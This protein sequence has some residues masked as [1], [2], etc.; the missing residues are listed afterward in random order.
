MEE[1]Q[2]QVVTL[3]GVQGC[4]PTV[5][6]GTD[7]IVLRDDFGGTVRLTKPQWTDLVIR[8]QAGELA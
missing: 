4:C 6:L 2:R 7:E 5:E 3:C 8:V 1:K